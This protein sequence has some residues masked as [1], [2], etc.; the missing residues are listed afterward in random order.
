MTD[1]TLYVTEYDGYS[2]VSGKIC[3]FMSFLIHFR[4][5]RPRFDMARPIFTVFFRQG[6]V[7]H[8][9]VPV[10]IFGA[11]SLAAGVLALLLPETH[12]QKLPETLEDAERFGRVVTE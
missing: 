4:I 1:M 7:T 5:S 6:Q 10:A 12:H 3:G 8:D 2:L 11:S 9:S